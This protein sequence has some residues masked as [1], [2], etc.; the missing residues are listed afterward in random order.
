MKMFLTR[1]GHQMLC[2]DLDACELGVRD[3]TTRMLVRK[4]VDS[5]DQQRVCSQTP[6]HSLQSPYQLCLYAVQQILK[7]E[8]WN[9]VRHVLQQTTVT[10]AS[11]L[12]DAILS[13]PPASDRRKLESSIRTLHHNSGHPRHVF[14]RMLRWKGA[15]ESVLA[16]AR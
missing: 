15:K 9:L 8:R 5:H 10:Q 7:M 16:A 2:S 14:V 12:D 1:C 6:E 3:E 4:R 11:E 13:A